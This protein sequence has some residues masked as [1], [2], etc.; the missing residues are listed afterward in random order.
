MEK[1]VVIMSVYR[2]CE[3]FFEWSCNELSRLEKRIK[4]LKKYAKE[5]GFRFI[6]RSIEPTANLDYE[7]LNR[8]V[9]NPSAMI[10]YNCELT[11]ED[12]EVLCEVA[13][14]VCCDDNEDMIKYTTADCPVM[15]KKSD[16]EVW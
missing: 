14:L 13:K 11:D 10:E 1:D 2:S 3:S 16:I 8:K 4:K 6:F 7:T 5:R 12:K 15:F 9:Y